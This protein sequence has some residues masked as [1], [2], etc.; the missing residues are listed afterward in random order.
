MLDRPRD[1]GHHTSF[2]RPSFASRVFP[3]KFLVSAVHSSP[4]PIAFV[5]STIEVESKVVVRR[6]VDVVISNRLG[7]IDT[8]KNIMTSRVQNNIQGRIIT[9]DFGVHHNKRILL[10]RLVFPLRS[11]T[12][13]KDFNLTINDTALYLG[14]FGLCWRPSKCSSIKRG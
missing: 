13:L 4:P 14:V 9:N 7:A 3:H 12:V 2:N 5:F 11:H 8:R 6:A 1:G 10:R